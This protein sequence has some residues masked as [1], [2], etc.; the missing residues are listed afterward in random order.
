MD[1]SQYPW[2]VEVQRYEYNDKLFR[3]KNPYQAEGFPREKANEGFIQFDI[4][5]PEFVV[6]YPNF[7]SGYN[8]KQD[9][10]Y[11]FNLED[12]ISTMDLQKT[13]L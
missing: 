8:N 11:L 3:L 1:P 13:R 12:T 5:D 9:Q 2:Q 10:L 4:S 6:V 7:Y